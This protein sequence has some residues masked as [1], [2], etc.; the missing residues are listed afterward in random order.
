[1]LFLQE[2]LPGTNGSLNGQVVEVE[3]SNCWV[4]ALVHNAQMTNNCLGVELSG[5]PRIHTVSLSSV[6]L[7]ETWSL[8]GWAPVDQAGIKFK[9]CIES[10]NMDSTTPIGSVQKI[11][12]TQQAIKCKK[13]TR[14]RGRG[15][16]VVGTR[17]NPR[18]IPGKELP[19][20]NPVVASMASTEN[21]VGSES[22]V[23][24]SKGRRI[25][26]KKQPS[27]KKG[28]SGTNKKVGDQG[29][30]TGGSKRVGKS[31]YT[32]GR[33]G[34][35]RSAR[36]GSRSN[37]GHTE[38]NDEEDSSDEDKVIKPREQWVCT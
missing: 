35:G 16:G 18:V 1:M 14:G 32:S 11:P 33:K 22:D 31:R 26:K 17:Q 28:A 30:C 21:N 6:R 9:S 27:K 3:E 25:S 29:I 13:N 38:G 8:Q 34:K 2:S 12:V 37:G 10:D 23:E 15:R 20:R 19:D 7:P 4:P 36:R 5:C 24:K